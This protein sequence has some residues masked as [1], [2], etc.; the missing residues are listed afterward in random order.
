MGKFGRIIIKAPGESGTLLTS[1]AWDQVSGIRWS[2][3]ETNDDVFQVM[4]VDRMIQDIVVEHEGAEYRYRD[5]CARWGGQCRYVVQSRNLDLP[6][7]TCIIVL[8]YK[9][10]YMVPVILLS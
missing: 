4:E 6:T 1:R 7:H 9:Y 10:K 5:V 2:P 3:A 8:E